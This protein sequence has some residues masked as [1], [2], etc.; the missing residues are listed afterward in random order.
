[1]TVSSQQKCQVVNVRKLERDHSDNKPQGSEYLGAFCVTV[2][3]GLFKKT[4]Q[5]KQNK[6]APLHLPSSLLFKQVQVCVCEMIVAQRVCFLILSQHEGDNST[7]SSLLLVTN[8]SMIVLIWS[9]YSLSS[10]LLLLFCSPRDSCRSSCRRTRHQ[11]SHQAFTAMSSLT[12]TWHLIV[13]SQLAWIC[14]T[15]CYRSPATQQGL[16]LDRTL[17]HSVMGSF[18]VRFFQTN[19]KNL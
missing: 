7:P 10:L 9:A 19:K 13:L 4:E 15:S 14:L 16:G 2:R 12:Y 8:I 6:T 11:T 18:R 3:W 17:L 1:M 5:N